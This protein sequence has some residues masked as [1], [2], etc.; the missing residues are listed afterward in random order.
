[1]TRE[2]FFQLRTQDITLGDHFAPHGDTD[3]HTYGVHFPDHGNAIECYGETE[4][5]AKKMASLV[6]TG[7]RLQ[8]FLKKTGE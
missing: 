3:M 8:L 7:L 1:M 5:I 2:K 4:D 6:V